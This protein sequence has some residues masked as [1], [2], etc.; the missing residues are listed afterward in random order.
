M[1]ELTAIIIDDEAQNLKLMNILISQFCRDV[2]ILSEG[3][4]VQ[5]AV[6]LVQRLQ[7]DIVFLDIDMPG[8]SGFELFN[9]IKDP[10]FAVIFTTAHTTE[11]LKNIKQAKFNFLL[12]PIDFRKLKEVIAEIHSVGL[13]KSYPTK[14]Q[15]KILENAYN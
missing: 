3:T 14:K 12:K 7:P 10:L 8:E 1:D 13:S 15:L 11:A 6:A 2:K 5:E 4:S 9:Y